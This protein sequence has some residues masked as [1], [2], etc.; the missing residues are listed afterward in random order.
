[1]R[2]LLTGAS[3]A[4]GSQLLPRL[5]ADGHRV[6]ALVRRP[7]SD[8]RIL[9]ELRTPA[10]GMQLG[11]TG[12]GGELVLA[13]VSTGL[14]LTRTLEGVEVAYYLIHSMQRARSGEGAFP[15][16]ERAAAENFAAAARRAGVRRIVYLGGPVVHGRAPSRHLAS[17]LSV[18]HILGEAVPELI[19]LRAS[20]VIGARSRSFRFMVRLIERMPV[21]TLP[22]WRS[23]RTRPIDARDV[24]EILAVGAS[25]AAIARPLNIG[26]PDT[27]SYEQMLMRIAEL[28]LVQRPT[29][30][31]AAGGGSLGPRLAAAIAG[32]DPELVMALMESLGGDLLVDDDRVGELARVRLHGFDAAV[33]HALAEWE[34]VEPLAAR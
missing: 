11:D 2:V 31:L 10:Q 19:A 15:A 28:M 20:I 27:L 18:E 17:R 21:L 26:G 30:A 4:I 23:N 29:L 3:G 8:P 25:V 9:A 22:P 16:R 6:R 34:R 1:M 14:G 13:D 7:V 5:L 24:T 33:E 12:D 32:E